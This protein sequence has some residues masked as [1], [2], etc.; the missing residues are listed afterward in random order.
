VKACQTHPQPRRLTPGV[1]LGKEIMEQSTQSIHTPG[2]RRG[3]P[4]KR[5]RRSASN[6]AAGF[7]VVLGLALAGLGAA[8][9]GDRY[10]VYISNEYSADISVIDSA[11]DEVI[12]TIDISGRPGEVRPRGLAVSPDGR[13]I[14]VSVSD[15]H[16]TLETDEDM[17]AVIDV[18][19]NEVVQQIRAGGNPERVAATPDGT[20]VWAALEA[21]AQGGG[22][23]V[24][25]GE[26]IAR[27][28]VGIEAEG[29]D[30]SP[31]GRWVYITA[32]TTHTVT[33]F[34]RHEMEVLKHFLVGNRPREVRFSIDGTRAYVTAEIGGTVS[35]V[36]TST[37]E[38]IDTINLG[39]DS[40][41][42]EIAV[43]PIR[44]RIYVVGGGTSA[45]YVI[46]T[47]SHEVIAT[48]REQMGRR[49]WGIAIT[50]DGSKIYTADGLSDSSTVID[51]ECLCVIGQV[52]T[53]RGSHSA[54]VG[55]IP[56]ED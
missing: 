53:G 25:T 1:T 27:F 51:P 33:V 24:E 17:I 15:F 14:Y 36:D 42:V 29:V 56:G 5:W 21:V 39:L 2:S 11:T 55:V 40:R 31:D 54:T 41:P 46:D 4:R 44:P 38:V 52:A 32:E 20:E 23:L 30:V 12:A 49:P 19:T 37:H 3:R 8:Q 9:Q 22:W 48:I 28:R 13:H 7:A 10:F 35:V 43:D 26:E 50:P 6:L 18:L 45:V 47:E 16:P 34:D